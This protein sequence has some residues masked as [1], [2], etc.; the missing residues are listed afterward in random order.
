MHVP[1]KSDALGISGN[2]N[3]SC[4]FPGAW[5]TWTST[6]DPN[7]ASETAIVNFDGSTSWNVT[8]NYPGQTLCASGTSSA[9]GSVIQAQPQSITVTVGQTATFTVTAG[10]NG[11]FTYQWFKNGAPIAGASSSTYT[12]PVLAASDNGEQFTVSV[13]N[14]GGTLNS[15]AATLTVANNVAPV[16]T[17]Q[18][19][20]SR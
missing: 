18:R 3:A 2:N 19:S 20:V 11:P 16:I 14:L 4:A 1:S 12:T 6:V 13:T 8:N 7:D 15:T 9:Q 5:S 17:T 10:G